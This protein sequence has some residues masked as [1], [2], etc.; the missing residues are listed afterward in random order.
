[1]KNDKPQ[2]ANR[3]VFMGFG[4]TTGIRVGEALCRGAELRGHPIRHGRDAWIVALDST[5]PGSDGHDPGDRVMDI[6]RD[7]LIHA[8][9]PDRESIERAAGEGDLYCVKREQLRNPG[10]LLAG[11]G[12]GNQPNYG[13]AL[14]RMVRRSV[15]KACTA[16]MSVAR[17]QRN[18][19]AAAVQDGQQHDDAA[20][21]CNIVFSSPGGT[22]SGAALELACIVH[23]AAD[24]LGIPV[25]I[26]ACV[27]DLGNLL[28]PNRDVA[29]RNRSQLFSG[30][31]AVLTGRYRDPQGK[32][33][34]S[35]RPLIDRL[36]VSSNMGRFN[37]IADLDTQVHHL[38]SFLYHLH[39]SPLGESMR[40]EITD[41]DSH[42]D[43]DETG[44]PRA[45][46]SFGLFAVD[47]D[48]ARV[49]THA[50][51]KLI[52]RAMERAR[53]A[54]PGDARERGRQAVAEH[55]CL[56]SEIES[57]CTRYLI[58]ASGKGRDAVEELRHAFRQLAR[59]GPLGRNPEAIREAYDSLSGEYLPNVLGP[60]LREN[61]RRLTEK[62]IA[63]SAQSWISLGKQPEGLVQY[64]EELEGADDELRRSD[65]FSGE[66]HET[67]IPALEAVN[68]E[69]NSASD[70]L[71]DID[72]RSL[73]GRMVRAA[74]RWDAAARLHDGCEEALR[75]QLEACAYE[76]AR[77]EVYRPLLDHC[78]KVLRSLKEIEAGVQQVHDQCQRQAEEAEHDVQP[79]LRTA[80]GFQLVDRALLQDFAQ[81]CF[82]DM[83]ED[84]LLALTVNG[85]LANHETFFEIFAGHSEQALAELQAIASRILDDR[86][87]G[88]DVLTVL[89]SRHSRNLNAIISR[90]V[91]DSLPYLDTKGEAGCYIALSKRI[92]FPK[93]S[94]AG[95]FLDT[96]SRLDPTEGDWKLVETDDRDSVVLMTYRAGVSTAALMEHGDNPM[97]GKSAEERIQGAAEP[98]TAVLPAGR[99][100]HGHAQV[101]AAHATAVG[102]LEHDDGAGY[103]L[104]LEDGRRKE[105]GA[106]EAQALQSL[107][108]DFGDIVHI[109]CTLAEGLRD[110]GAVCLRRVAELDKQAPARIAALYDTVA[111][112]RALDEAK[113][114]LP[115]MAAL[116]NGK[117]ATQ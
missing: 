63:G 38:A 11:T 116:R 61:A 52:A 16:G 111:L 40:Q 98:V 12:T 24:E 9:L 72:Q 94:D 23:E 68:E 115:Y 100:T 45:G 1:M 36:I 102:L 26:T 117:A 2:R 91:K 112:E 50:V 110:E 113:E 55:Q 7:H 10:A 19:M 54:P 84:N 35:R 70:I 67:I 96:A 37:Q 25:E 105:L 58:G 95:W 18:K 6:I 103:L 43:K 15:K 4:G 56:E 41:I 60:R 30:L 21:L 78:S 81:G 86:V 66:R 57:Q 34:Y 51:N 90:I 65:Q 3:L 76:I 48:R 47:L 73:P 59:S 101:A 93:G 77:E 8:Q 20:L 14:V 46:S 42:R 5:E 28:P 64:K 27:V 39:F 104:R 97:N 13:K 79:S 99:T 69:I 74:R 44:V 71:D 109:Y 32:Y 87:Q 83:G 82:R 88:L 89:R 108:A 107:Q 53:Q 62:F 106:N 33:D 92:G 80:V 49:R 29:W 114:L 31:R 17:D 22:G 75:L 85:V